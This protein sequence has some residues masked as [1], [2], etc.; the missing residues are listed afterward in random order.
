M[1]GV[2]IV[3]VIIA[4]LYFIGKSNA[5]KPKDA[6]EKNVFK[7]RISSLKFPDRIPAIKWHS[8]KIQ[9]GLKTG[10]IELANLSYAKLY[11]SVRQQNVKEKGKYD[12]LLQSIKEE[13]EKFR[14]EFS[15]DY[16]QQF[17]PPSERINAKTQKSKKSENQI[18]YLETLNYSELPKDILKHI[19]IVRTVSEWNKIG[20]KPKKDKYGRWN[21]IKRK[22]RY[23]EFSAA[24]IKNR[25]HRVSLETGKRITKKPYFIKALVDQNIAISDF[26]KNSKDLEYFVN[27]VN[28]FDEK[29]YENAQNE[30]NKAL[31]VKR[32]SDYEDLKIQIEIK[33]NNEIVAEEQFKK[34][35]NDI[36]SAIH[37]D[38][39][40]DWLRVL[41]NNQ[42]FDK[43]LD[44]IKQTNLTLDKLANG[45]ISPKIYGKQ[46]QDWYLHKKEQ[47]NQRL[48]YL[49][50]IKRINFQKSEN[51]IKFL[52]FILEISSKGD[53]KLIEKVAD[54]FG[55]WQ[56][57]ERAEILYK[58]CL[59][60]LKDENK[61]RMK[62]RIE[63]KI[64]KLKTDVNK[65]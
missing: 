5:N 10:N 15:V 38:E 14:V 44:W 41:I 45:E 32:Q 2:V 33:L 19:D 43:A 54:L 34:Y 31:E 18:V 42:K 26:V 8:E 7:S 16:P 17:L 46:S 61:P 6:P 12:N 28:L 27:A 53:Y 20:F 48:K 22:G 4:F 11:E 29:N 65:A 58:E 24:D 55:S 21:A 37:T 13:Y 9:Q 59:N 47:F 25:I 60:L 49:V 56:I 57:K 39:M 3:I 62:S 40:N 1:T 51:S 52:E 36:D 35:E 50:D 64:E 30:I 23:F 63:K